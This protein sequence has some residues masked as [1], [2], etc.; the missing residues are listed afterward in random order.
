MSKFPCN[1]VPDGEHASHL[2]HSMT[3][4][5]RN[6]ALGAVRSGF[7]TLMVGEFGPGFFIAGVF[8]PAH[9][10]TVTCA[11]RGPVVGDPALSNSETFSAG[12]IRNSCYPTA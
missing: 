2:D 3:E 7:S 4:A 11:L 10:G 5:Q 12:D 1:I 6:Y 8:L 9:M